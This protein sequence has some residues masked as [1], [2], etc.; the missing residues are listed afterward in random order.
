[1]RALKE[2]SIVT[3]PAN[4]AARVIDV[5]GTDVLDAIESADTLRELEHLLRDAAGLSKAGA[6]ALVARCK[7]LA[8]RGEPAQPDDATFQALQL[9]SRLN[10]LANAA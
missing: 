10:R 5:K 6:A 3:T 7:S 2:I 9:A 8:V 1:V 4:A